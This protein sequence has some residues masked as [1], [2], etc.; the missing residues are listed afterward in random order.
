VC[1]ILDIDFI[2]FFEYDLVIFIDPSYLVNIETYISVLRVV[3]PWQL[4]LW[5]QAIVPLGAGLYGCENY[6]VSINIVS[7]TDLLVL[8]SLI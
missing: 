4:Y 2:C 8:I 1:V 6:C 3:N 7:K 5:N